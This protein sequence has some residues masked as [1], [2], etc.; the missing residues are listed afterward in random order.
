MPEKVPKFATKIIF[1][2]PWENDVAVPKNKLKRF[3][4]CSKRLRQM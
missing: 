4:V 1:M 3:L 2:G